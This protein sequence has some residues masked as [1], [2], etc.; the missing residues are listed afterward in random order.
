MKDVEIKQRDGK[1]IVSVDVENVKTNFCQ[2]VEVNTTK[3]NIR[4]FHNCNSRCIGYL[5]KGD[6]VDIIDIYCAEDNL[7]WGKLSE[8]HFNLVCNNDCFQGWIC[9][10]YC[11]TVMKIMC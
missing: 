1:L 8:E 9:L 11:T 10:N 2:A 4:G 6:R 5:R 3:L 7:V